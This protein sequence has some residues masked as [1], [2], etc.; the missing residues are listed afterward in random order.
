TEVNRHFVSIARQRGFYS[1]ELMAKVIDKGSLRCAPGVPPDVHRLF[2]TAF[3]IP[4]ED[5]IEMQA[6]FQEYT[7]NAVSKTI[8]LPKRAKHEDV[9][10]AFLMAYEKG[11]KGITVFRYGSKRGTLVRFEDID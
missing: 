3:E 1:E 6:A 4:A 2:R 9:A 7:D 11:V 8:N 5:H 10:R